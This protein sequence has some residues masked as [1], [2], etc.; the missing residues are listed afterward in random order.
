MLPK[1]ERYKKGTFL[2]F[3]KTLRFDKNIAIALWKL[4]KERDIRGYIFKNF[5]FELPF[6]NKYFF[7][8][9]ARKIV[10]SLKLDEFRYAKGFGGVRP[11]VLNKDEQRLLLGEASVYTGEGLIF[12]MTP[13][14]GATSCLGNAE[15]DLRYIVKYLGKTFDEAK[16]NDELTDGEYCVLPEPIASQKAIVNLIRAEIQRTQEKYLKDIHQGKP[17]ADFWD[18]PHSKI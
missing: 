13:S 5:L 12:N 2:D 17:D 9:D 16:F 4:L 11:Q 8:K 14:P 3:F 10:P 6:F 7:L 15:R 18:K 1:L